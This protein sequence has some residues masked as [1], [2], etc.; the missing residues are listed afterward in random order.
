MSDTQLD[1]YSFLDR[2]E[3]ESKGRTGQS[4]PKDGHLHGF[5]YNMPYEEYAKVDALNA[6]KSVHMRRSPMYYRYALTHPSPET[7][8]TILGTLVHRLIL[9]PEVE[10]A[11]SVWG[12]EKWMKV[13]NGGEWEKWRESQGE[14]QIVTVKEYEAVM[15]MSVCAL[16]HAP[17]SRYA[18]A[19][20]P[21]EVCMF[22][23]HEV[24]GR[25]MKARLDKL[26]PSTHTIPDLKTTRDSRPWRF[27]PQAY[28]LGYVL[29]MAHYWSGYK[30]LKG[31]EPKVKLLAL[32]SKPPHE[33]VVYNVSRDMLLLGLE[34]CEKLI[35]KID[36]CEAQKRWPALEQDEVELQMPPWASPEED[37]ELGLEL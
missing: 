15:Q 5:V 24:T 33:S 23:R 36:E 28:S 32:E 25:R 21:T 16:T 34:E 3:E 37:T 13:R 4:D 27:G 11:I 7:T 2:T 29:K 8:A 10:N 26:I 14:N 12:R 18:T 31:I 1:D 17:V 19:E 9:E 35:E 30:T 6:S 20:G 22:W